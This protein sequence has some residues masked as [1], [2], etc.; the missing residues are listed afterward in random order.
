MSVPSV[1][2][3]LTFKDEDML[4]V[5]IDEAGRGP[6]MGRVYAA[7]VMWPP[8]LKPTVLIDDSKKLKPAQLK[9]AYDYI[10]KHALA[11]GIAYATED[12]IESLNILHA[13]MHAMHKA[14]NQCVLIPDQILV[15]GN[16]FDMYFD[17][18]GNPVEYSTVE[19]GD[20]KYIS[21]AAASILAKW[22]RDQYVLDLCDQYPE[23]D[24]RYSIKS[25]KGYGSKAHTDG[26][27][28]YGISQFHRK[29]F[30]SSKNAKLNIVKEKS[31]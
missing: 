18:E 3:L 26:I 5:G 14:I 13:T 30:K 27:A 4:E 20:G 29:T 19:Q 16:Y 2:S 21:I 24:E 7:A 1:P 25:N 17:D 9:T 11:Y 15:D 10:K 22:E 6:L 31:T 28:K 12:E 8:D 23:L